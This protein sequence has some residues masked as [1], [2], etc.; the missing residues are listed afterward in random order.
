M[1][2][3]LS[4][5]LLS[6]MLFTSFGV[7]TVHAV[8]LLGEWLAESEIFESVFPQ[9]MDAPAGNKVVNGGRFTLEG[10]TFYEGEPIM[11]TPTVLLTDEDWIGVAPK[12]TITKASHWRYIKVGKGMETDY[13][14]SCWG[15]GVG[16]PFDLRTSYEAVTDY[17]GLPAGEYTVFF[18]TGSGSAKNYETTTTVDITVLKAPVKVNKSTYYEGNPIMTTVSSVGAADT[19]AWVGIVPV[20]E[21]KIVTTYGCIR[22][23]YVSNMGSSA[24]DM[25][26]GTAMQ[27]TGKQ[28]ACAA[29]M[30][31]SVEV[32]LEIPAGSYAMLYVPSGKGAPDYTFATQFKVKDVVTTTT[33][34]TEF[35]AGEAIEVTPYGSGTDWVGITLGKDTFAMA[36]HWRYIASGTG[37]G[38]KAG[39]GSGTSIDLR[40]AHFAYSDS[41]YEGLPAGFYTIYVSLNDGKGSAALRSSA[42]NI[43]VVDEVPDAPNSV[44][45]QLDNAR[46]GF[47]AGKVTVNYGNKVNAT[48]GS[49]PSQVIL[50]WGKNG[51]PLDGYTHIGVRP[52][53]GSVTEIEMA[54]K[55]VIPEGATQLLVYGY[56]ECGKSL[57]PVV[58]DLPASRSYLPT[59]TLK[60]T[61][62]ICSDIHI[63]SGN[64]NHAYNKNFEAFMADIKKVDPNTKGIFVSG[65]A[66]DTGLAEEYAYLRTL[67]ANANLGTGLYLALGNHDYKPGSTSGYSD[68]YLGKRQNY[69][70][71]ANSFLPAADRMTDNAYYDAW[72]NG[73]H[74]IFL[75][76][77]YAG[78]HAYLSDQQLEFLENALAENRDPS[79]PIFI[80]LHQPMYDTVAG[81][82][83][84][85]GWNGVIAGTENYNI[86][87]ANGA[88]SPAGTYE[89]PL[90]D[91]LSKYPEAMMF[92]GHS[93]WDMT[94]EHNMF[95]GNE[96]LPNYLFNTASVAYLWSEVRIPAGERWKLGHAYYVR[97]YD[98]Y[99]ELYG[100]DV[101]SGKW[102]PNA[103]YRVD[104]VPEAYESAEKV[105]ANATLCG[106]ALSL[107]GNIGMNVYL[108]L[109]DALL[110]ASGAAVEFRYEDGTKHSVP[111]AN[112]TMCILGNDVVY[113]FVCPVDAACMTEDVEIALVAGSMDAVKHT[114]S[115]R[116]LA[117]TALTNHA[118]N[119]AVTDTVKAMLHY[120]A[121]TQTYFG[122]NTGTLANV[123]LSGT[124][125]SSV[126]VDASHK[127]VKTGSA[128]GL[129]Y[130]G[131]AVVLNA[132]PLVRHY[133]TATGDIGNY[134]FKVN[135]STVAVKQNGEGYFVEVALDYA[136]MA[137]KHTLSVGGF[138]LQY[139]GMSY[140]RAVLRNPAAYD[141]KLVNVLTALALYASA[142][143]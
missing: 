105:S 80:M 130:V 92:G 101:V 129:T 100:R 87:R 111:V 5:L 11:V 33:G 67:W 29:A 58:V 137:T 82:M 72:V 6:A 8:S 76:S 91:I 135:G 49:A 27:D 20:I 123:A 95:T 62:Q 85:D 18:V 43:S 103:M 143:Q 142:L 119:A 75:A 4:L 28:A 54:E 139:S 24:F 120:G 25:R 32:M 69:I 35:K 26:T 45:Y 17:G 114:V 108:K 79:R 13:G 40:Q 9:R 2:K 89:K 90:H 14:Q 36:V 60:S 131:S 70:D 77:E 61:F 141:T 116:S 125:L 140:L 94:S 21:D 124:G 23:Q 48:D 121:Y 132:T 64:P 39:Q 10:T 98:T 12:G 83:A 99:V 66:I 136:E 81:G 118:F 138:T 122:H 134:T 55:S 31:V 59:G 93:H 113:R 73:I 50:Y 34:R 128:A 71:G 97:V 22:W 42:I 115:L 52:L 126:S 112:G 74:Y 109:S 19:G 7:S 78:T 106:T 51:K 41:K 16:V 53:K 65:D 46:T 110:T 37:S 102:V 84:D 30:G 127:A 104:L 38:E 86:W 68:D 47:A 1:K 107:D 3:V 44:T 88:K 56:N 63:R 57:S 117:A 96:N 133:F 15:C